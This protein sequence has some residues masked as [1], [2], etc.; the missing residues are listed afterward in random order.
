M[1]TALID[2]LKVLQRRFAHYERLTDQEENKDI[3]DI[4]A[5]H[6]TSYANDILDAAYKRL[7]ASDNLSR[8]LKFYQVRDFY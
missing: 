5:L 7:K 2:S 4:L 1:Q 6:Y 8:Y 3:A